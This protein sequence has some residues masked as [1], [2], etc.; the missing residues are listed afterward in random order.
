M[1]VVSHR[2][3]RI[4]NNSQRNKEMKNEQSYPSR[5]PR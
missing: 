5:E 3:M 4:V 2:Q 1:T